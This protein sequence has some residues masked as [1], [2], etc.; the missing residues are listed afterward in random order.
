MLSVQAVQGG[1]IG[2]TLLA[3]WFEPATQKPKDVAAVARTIDFS[4]GWLILSC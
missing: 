4:V 2:L 3:Y 1:Q